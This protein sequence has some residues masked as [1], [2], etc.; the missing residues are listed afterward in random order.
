MNVVSTLEDGRISSTN[1]LVEM[2]ISEYLTLA[3]PILNRNEFQRR[4]VT[5]SKTVYALLKQD[6]LRGCVIPPIV[7]ALTDWGG[8]ARPDKDSLPGVVFEHIDKLIILDGLQRSHSLV[9]LH[10]ELTERGDATAIARLSELP[11]RCEFYVGINRLGILYRMLTLNTGQTPMS[12]RQQI[13]MLYLDYAQHPPAGINLIRESDDKVATG[14]NDFNFRDVIE[15]FNS[16][17]ERNELPLERADL[18]ENIKSL[19]KLSQENADRDIFNDFLSTW[20]IFNNRLDVITNSVELSAEAIA[21]NGRPWG[22][23]AVQV[24]KRAQA[25]SGFGAAVGRLKDFGLIRGFQEVQDAL[26]NL[27]VLDDPNAFLLDINKRMAWISANAKKIGN[28]QRM[29][30]QYFFRELLNRD[31]DSYLNLELAVGAAF[32]KY[33]SQTV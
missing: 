19:E 8:G 11:I 7:L 4:R 9:D 30:F 33:Q 1:F 22:K 24:F 12:L 14:L 6:I 5:S 26:N 31:G 15:G 16:Y 25:I 18:L 2:P 27:A 3:R 21:E 17:L 29:Y 20:T 32:K 10:S 13:E 28:E 23:N